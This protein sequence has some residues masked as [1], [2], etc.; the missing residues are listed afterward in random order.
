VKGEI[1]ARSARPA[2]SLER[3]Q[4]GRTDFCAHRLGAAHGNYYTEAITKL[5]ITGLDPWSPS[6]NEGTEGYKVPLKKKKV[7][8]DFFF[9]FLVE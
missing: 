9:S 8:G 7:I 4:S 3:G 2:A 6:R 1:L 5:L